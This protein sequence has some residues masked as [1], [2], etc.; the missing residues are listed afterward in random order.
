M[1]KPNEVILT[2]RPWALT[3]WL[4]LH[5]KNQGSSSEGNIG[6]VSEPGFLDGQQRNL[7]VSNPGLTDSNVFPKSL[8]DKKFPWVHIKNTDS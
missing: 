3:L 7:W 2:A 6:Q 4:A 8:E 1:P 5:V